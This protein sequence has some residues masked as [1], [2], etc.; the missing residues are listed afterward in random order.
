MDITGSNTRS[1]QGITDESTEQMELIITN[2]TMVRH[3]KRLSSQSEQLD[4]E[5]PENTRARISP[6]FLDPIHSATAVDNNIP[7]TESLP[8]PLPCLLQ[9]MLHTPELEM[10]MDVLRGLL[11]RES[12]PGYTILGENHR[13]VQDSDEVVSPLVTTEGWRRKMCE[14]YYEVVDHFGYDREVVSFA[15]NYLDR[16]MA[17][18]VHE[19]TKPE[20][21]R[22]GYQLVAATA[23]YLAS[24]LHG[25]TDPSLGPSRTLKI[26]EFSKL[27]GDKF[28]VRTLENMELEL[29]NTLSWKV[30]PTTFVRCVAALLALLPKWSAFDYQKPMETVACHLFELARYLTE[31][32]VCRSCFTFQFKPLAV[33]YASIICAIDR[34]RT[35]PFDVRVEFVRR[36]A[37]ATELFPSSPE[38]QEA[39]LLHRRYHTESLSQISAFVV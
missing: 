28:S 36:V 22:C 19:S 16:Y 29:L 25:E 18:R 5:E 6:N 27:T 4:D 37:V 12:C 24:K 1:M 14:W 17:K 20:M 23:L 7:F 10:N 9:Q 39:C 21:D 2:A 30:N 32:A 38:V 15:L 13:Y 34:D 11:R 3:N 35:F 8:V 33:A 26:V 31:L